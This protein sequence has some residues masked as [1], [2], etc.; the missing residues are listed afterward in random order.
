LLNVLVA[1]TELNT[2]GI[3]MGHISAENIVLTNGDYSSEAPEFKLFNFS[4][5]YNHGS[6]Y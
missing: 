5:V 3:S 6:K 4:S 1:V 2:L